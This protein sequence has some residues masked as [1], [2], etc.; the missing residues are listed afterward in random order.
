MLIRYNL[1]IILSILIHLALFLVIAV[2]GINLNNNKSQTAITVSILSLPAQKESTPA[3]K[4]VKHKHNIKASKKIKKADLLKTEQI[5]K[6]EQTKEK[7][8]KDISYSKDTY[9]IGSKHNPL[10]P[11]P[12]MAKLRNYQ[13]KVEICVITDFEGNV[14]NVHIYNSSGY[15][16]LDNSA[17]K[18][19]NKWRFN[20]EKLAN[21]ENKNQ[22]YQIIVPIH[23]VLG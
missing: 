20:I 18:T 11:Y 16:L 4:V 3:K 17:L 21:L 2:I 14:I 19:L 5:S 23:F 8:I 13:G 6:K 10:P 22:Y 9:K 15:Q 12:R 1:P 7:I